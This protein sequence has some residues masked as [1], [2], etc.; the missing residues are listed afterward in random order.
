MENINQIPETPIIQ[1]IQTPNPVKDKNIFKILFFISIFVLIGVVVGVYF[2]LNNKIAKLSEVKS[3]EITTQTVIV[4]T[5]EP[6]IS[7]NSTLISLDSNKNLYTNSKFGF[8]L[9][10]PKFAT[11]SIECRK[12][13]DSYR[14]NSGDVSIN[15]FENDDTIYLAGD[16]F[17]RLTGEQK[18]A[19]GRY[20]YS[21]CQKENTT[22]DLI[23]KDRE[24]ITTGTTS[25]KIY[26]TN[27]KNDSELESYFKSKYGS[28]CRLGEK[29][30]SN[31]PD[32]Y[33]VKILGDGKDLDESNCPINFVVVTAYNPTKG[34]LV[35]FELGQA[36]NLTK[37]LTDNGCYD[38]EIVSSLKFN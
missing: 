18:T 4:P 23:K 3:D 22:F 11:G 14:P 15:F 29:T 2:I 27:I 21:G 32:I 17:Y 25:L 34:K 7:Q 37:K 33:N 16:Y 30:L 26:A 19:D 31:T 6:T 38:S 10:V 28:G 8:S 24:G 12:E 36:C 35:M 13:V 20:N 9:I 5:V 1:P